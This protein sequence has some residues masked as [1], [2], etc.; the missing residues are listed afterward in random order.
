MQHTSF[1]RYATDA[2]ASLPSTVVRISV[3]LRDH[4]DRVHRALSEARPATG[5][6]VVVEPV[7]LPDSQLDH[8]VLWTRTQAAVAFE[9]VAA[10]QTPACLVDRLLG[11]ETAD[12]LVEIS[13]P[14]LRRELGLLPAG[15]V[16]EVPE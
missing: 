5:A 8:G 14:F 3:G 1:S 10:R 11:G 6:A 16:S 4:L 2:A 12:H 9:A 13:D 15:G 7:A